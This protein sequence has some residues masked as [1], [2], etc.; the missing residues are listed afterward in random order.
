MRKTKS[1]REKKPATKKIDQK[2]YEKNKKRTREKT[3]D[4]KIEQKKLKAPRR[5]SEQVGLKKGEKKPKVLACANKKLFCVQRK[6]GK[7]ILML[8]KPNGLFCFLLEDFFSFFY[9][10]RTRDVFFLFFY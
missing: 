8:R 3:G 2:N 7:K 9:G 6:N 4:K 5:R 1:A 10:N